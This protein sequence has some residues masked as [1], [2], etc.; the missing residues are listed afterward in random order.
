MFDIAGLPAKACNKLAAVEALD[1]LIPAPPPLPP[2]LFVIG[3]DGNVGLGGDLEHSG[4]RLADSFELVVA[5]D[6]FDDNAEEIIFS[7]DIIISTKKKLKI[8]TKKFKKE[9]FEDKFK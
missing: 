7:G 8:S 1:S 2:V 9:V 5:V 3:F 4:D 6:E